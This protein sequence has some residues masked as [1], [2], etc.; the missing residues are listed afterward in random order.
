VDELYRMLGKEHEGDLER[1]A[2]TRRRA[3]EID[4]RERDHDG[5]PSDGSQQKRA[6]PFL[7]RIAAAFARAAR[8]ES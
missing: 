1:E 6:R 5:A 4:R 2:L 3:A 8:A 7:S